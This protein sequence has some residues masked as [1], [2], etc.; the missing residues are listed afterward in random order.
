MPPG[1]RRTY[2]A[3]MD[4]LLV[5][6][7]V[8]VSSLAA[9]GCNASFPDGPTPPPAVRVGLHL[10]FVQ[11]ALTPIWQGT[12]VT[13]QAL[14]LDSDALYTDVSRQATWTSSNPAVMSVSGG[15]V[16]AL[17]PGAAEVN[18]TLGGLS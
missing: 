15:V 7:F 11:S 4:C 5:G 10:Q 16:R 6:L 14:A 1:M 2:A 8:A 9:T 12:S 17:T 18:A 3:S 13:L